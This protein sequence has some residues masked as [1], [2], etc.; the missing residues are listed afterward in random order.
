MGKPISIRKYRTGI[1]KFFIILVVIVN[2]SCTETIINT[3]KS[4]PTFQGI[5]E[6]NP[7]TETPIKEPTVEFNDSIKKSNPNW[8]LLQD[9][10][11][12]AIN[13]FEDQYSSIDWQGDQRVLLSLGYDQWTKLSFPEAI[14]YVR[15]EIKKILE[16]NS[17]IA[18]VNDIRDNLSDLDIDTLEKEGLI[19]NIDTILFVDS[20]RFGFTPLEERIPDSSEYYGEAFVQFHTSIFDVEKGYYL[21]VSDIV[22]D[23]KEGTIQVEILTKSTEDITNNRTPLPTGS[24]TQLL[25]SMPGVRYRE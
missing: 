17:N 22:Y 6:K 21:W 8:L 18:L 5:I 13:N 3:S 25:V 2:F 9:T 24:K 11:D 10:I 20:L 12:Q 16:N 15:I 14:E 23:T 19:T 7:K 4:T 1:S